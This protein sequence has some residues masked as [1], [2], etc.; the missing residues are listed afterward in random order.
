MMHNARSD[1]KACPAYVQRAD[2]ACQ[3]DA[4]K[5]AWRLREIE[6]MVHNHVPD[7]EWNRAITSALRE[8][9]CELLPKE[10][11]NG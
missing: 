6:N 10:K 7:E 11:S 2:M 9:I 1:S 3:P 8:V 4:K 5:L